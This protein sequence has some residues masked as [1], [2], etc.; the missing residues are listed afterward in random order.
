MENQKHMDDLVPHGIRKPPGGSRHPGPQLSSGTVGVRQIH[1]LVEVE[2]DTPRRLAR[3]SLQEPL[4][5][6]EVVLESG[7]DG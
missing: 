6:L 2:N 5:T 1:A 7:M 4:Q 3:R